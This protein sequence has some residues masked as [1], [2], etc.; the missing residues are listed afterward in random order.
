V[1]RPLR[2]QPV[3]PELLV[4]LST[5]DD[6]AVYLVAP[7]RAIVQ[8]LDFFPPIVDD[9]YASGAIAA[10]NAMSDVYA[11]GG[12]V[13]FGLAIVAWPEDV[14]LAL[15]E[16]AMRGMAE[17][18]REGDAVI[19]G[20]HTVID[21]E[22]KLGLAV[23]GQVDP[24]QLLLKSMLRSGDA[25][26]LTKP[27]GT[28]LLT[29]AH[30][31]GDLS[32][33]DLA[34]AIASMTAPNREA[35]RA[36]RDAGLHAAT[37]ITGFA[38]VGHAY[39]MAERSGVGVRIEASAMPLLPGARAHA[40]RGV[41]FGGAQRNRDHFLHP[42][43]VRLEGIDAATERLLVDPQTSGG[44]LVGVPAAHAAAWTRSCEER[45]VT[46]WRIGEAVEGAG[47]SVTA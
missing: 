14:D 12:D 25:L 35:A 3:P 22:P 23:T 29:T 15:L 30:K 5:S 20:G 8:T 33:A 38:L 1:L 9:A 27:I 43:R 46:A 13:L 47:V 39:E 45:G 34:S 36:A 2:E 32:A 28:G 37:D 17:T 10:A 4:G 18:M 19:A 41:H 26:Y 7:D 11:M 21:R 40:E 24:K 31:L 44:L 6:A 42:D 16:A